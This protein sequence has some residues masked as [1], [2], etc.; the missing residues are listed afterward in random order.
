MPVAPLLPAYP[1]T[2]SEVVDALNKAMADAFKHP[3][4]KLQKDG[5]Y[6]I[7]FGGKVKSSKAPQGIAYDIE[8]TME[9]SD[10]VVKWCRNIAVLN[11]NLKWYSYINLCKCDCMEYMEFHHK[12]M[13]QF[14]YIV[15]QPIPVPAPSVE[16]KETITDEIKVATAPKPIKLKLKKS[17][18]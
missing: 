18:P 10:Y 9:V 6:R 2:E 17:S 7:S 8:N 14:E 1:I 5:T 4:L 13:V 12:L 16:I 15:F 11:P 3:N